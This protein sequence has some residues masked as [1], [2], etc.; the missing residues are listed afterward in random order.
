MCITK[1]E[2]LTGNRVQHLSALIILSP[3]WNRNTFDR[4]RLQL[5]RFL[6]DQS[7]L[8]V[9][10]LEA[11]GLSMP[12]IY[13][14]I[15]NS[16]SS[17]SL[18]ELRLHGVED[19]VYSEDIN[20]GVNPIKRF[21]SI[22]TRILRNM[23]TSYPHLVKLCIELTQQDIK[24]TSNALHE[25]SLFQ[26]LR[27]LE[28]TTLYNTHGT[29]PHGRPVTMNHVV[30]VANAVWS[31][32]LKSFRLRV[33]SFDGNQ[34]ERRETKRWLTKC[35]TTGIMTTTDEIATDELRWR[36]VWTRIL[37]VPNEKPDD[38]EEGSKWL[39]GLMKGVEQAGKEALKALR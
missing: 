9:L 16:G 30:N 14:F 7:R 15:R 31:S 12:I 23:G 10:E 39:N 28:I 17:N 29:G 11:P 24:L 32:R 26:S 6:R 36:R 21:R 3:L 13:D 19:R 27:H 8:E 25:L 18:T 2:V 1:Y 37:G 38:A 20:T 22:D 4:H 33:K 5:A 35:S 34:S